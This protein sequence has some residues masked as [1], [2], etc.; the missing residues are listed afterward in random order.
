MESLNH[1]HVGNCYYLR[2][3]LTYQTSDGL[4]ASVSCPCLPACIQWPIHAFS[5]ESFISHTVGLQWCFSIAKCNINVDIH[6]WSQLSWTSSFLMTIE[7]MVL[8][9]FDMGVCRNT[10]VSTKERI[11]HCNHTNRDVLGYKKALVLHEFNKTVLLGIY[12]SLGTSRSTVRWPLLQCI[13]CTA[14][15]SLYVVLL[16]LQQATSGWYRSKVGIGRPCASKWISSYCSGCSG[17]LEIDLYESYGWNRT[18]L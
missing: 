9:R 1:F 15:S 10:F 7:T 18:G 16:S 3:H 6:L 2:F 8:I 11:F 13:L 17:F 14:S 4:R 12:K 5:R